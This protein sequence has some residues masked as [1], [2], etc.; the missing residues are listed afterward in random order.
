MVD[1]QVQNPI[2][3]AASFLIF[4]IQQDAPFYSRC[5]QQ[6]SKMKTYPRARFHCSSLCLSVVVFFFLSCLSHAVFSHISPNSLTAIDGQHRLLMVPLHLF[7]QEKSF[8][9][10]KKISSRW[11]MGFNETGYAFFFLFWKKETKQNKMCTYTYVHTG[12]HTHI[13]LL[14]KLVSECFGSMECLI[15]AK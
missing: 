4:F 8:V 12:R 11:K 2:E 15:L 13:F 5:L 6:T 10:A 1:F 14:C 9:T 3:L 7:K